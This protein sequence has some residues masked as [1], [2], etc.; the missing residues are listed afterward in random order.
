[1]L[2]SLPSL[3]SPPANA[4]EALR[5]NN[6]L[7]IYIQ[8]LHEDIAL[9]KATPSS[10]REV[11]L[12]GMLNNAAANNWKKKINSSSKAWKNLIWIWMK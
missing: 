4:E 11:A 8:K 12:A 3:S 5:Q 6:A 9:L 2:S 10:D 7:R 1:M